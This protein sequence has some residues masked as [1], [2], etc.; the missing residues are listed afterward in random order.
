MQDDLPSVPPYSPEMIE[1]GTCS[2]KRP[3][4]AA[5]C[6]DCGVC[7]DGLD[8]HCP[9]TGKCI[10]KKT[11][12]SFYYFLWFLCMHIGFVLVGTIYALVKDVDIFAMP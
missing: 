5:H 3:Y 10:G 9:W 4:T 1:C 6:Y 7:V 8:H 12:T 2:V 11:I